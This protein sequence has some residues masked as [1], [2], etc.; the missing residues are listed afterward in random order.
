ME[1]AGSTRFATLN[2]LRRKAEAELNRESS[3]SVCFDQPPQHELE[4][5]QLELQMQNEALRESQFELE[6][7]RDRYR[8]LY[9]DAPVGYVTL[10]A[11]GKILEANQA[12]AA[13]LGTEREE[14]EVSWLSSFMTVQDS[15]IFHLHRMQVLEGAQSQR[16]ELRLI[17]RHG[18]TVP[19][20][21]QSSACANPQGGEPLCRC[22]I[23]DLSELGEVRD[24][25]SSLEQRSSA[26]LGASDAVIGTTAHGRIET[27]SPAA[28]RLFGWPA[29]EVIGEQV[30]TLIRPRSSHGDTRMPSLPMSAQ[31]WDND[32]RHRFVGLRRDGTT[33]NLELGVAQWYEGTER[34]L[35]YVIRDIT[36]QLQSEEKIR[37]SE[38]RFNQIAEHI[39]EMF[40]VYE[41]TGTFSYLSPAFED[42]W[43]RSVQEAYDEPAMVYRSVHPADRHT[44]ATAY[45]HM[46]RGDPF[47]E[48]LRI[49][50]TDGALRWIQLRAFPVTE[51]GTVARVVI[52]V[53]DITQEKQLE[54]ELRQAQKL[55]AVGTFASQIAHDFGNILQVISSSAHFIAAQDT[56]PAEVQL[57]KGKIHEAVKRGARLVNQLMAHARSQQPEPT[58]MSLDS[59]VEASRELLESLLGNDTRL[60][61]QCKV[62]HAQVLAELVHI[63]QILLNLVANARDAMPQGGTVTIATARVTIRGQDP[64][65]F[66]LAKAGRYVRLSVSDTGHGMDPHTQ[67]RV[68]EP[69]FTTKAGDRGTGLGLS[70]VFSITRTLRGGVAVQSEV[71]VGTTFNIYLPLYC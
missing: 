12:A 68:F 34:K 8:E 57:Y 4:L 55:E 25:A 16:C 36:H 30:R 2:E 23:I 33:F 1:E 51:Q 44:V 14:L 10:D 58:P 48:E 52:V 15:D 67:Q 19:V 7:S 59:V 32:S 38:A 45:Q 65:R 20:R 6:V 27:F 43:Q 66:G 11:T 54:E 18:D 70:T 40:G 28:E 64:R 42:I 13:M 53:R 17:T 69:F 60:E 63:E 5:Y 50:R 3:P 26:L 35:A 41:L 37:A 71:G 39:D 56:S 22:V 21:I 61:L 9:H 47:D 29:H 49:S 46:L 24:R 62:P 31:E